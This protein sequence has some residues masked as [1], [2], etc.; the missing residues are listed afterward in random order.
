MTTYIRPR[1]EEFFLATL[2]LVGTL[3]WGYF[4][5]LG[6]TSNV[7]RFNPDDGFNLTGFILSF[8]LLCLAVF[9]LRFVLNV[10]RRLW[11]Q[12][13]SWLETLATLLLGATLILGGLFSVFTLVVTAYHIMNDKISNLAFT[14]GFS[15]CIV[16]LG[17]AGAQFLV[18]LHTFT[19]FIAGPEVKEPE[20]AS[21]VTPFSK[22]QRFLHGPNFGPQ[23]TGDQ[24][25]GPLLLENDGR[26]S[27]IEEKSNGRPGLEKTMV[28]HNGYHI[29]TLGFT[30]NGTVI[31]TASSGGAVHFQ[32]GGR[33]GVM[34]PPELKF[35]DWNIGKIQTATMGVPQTFLTSQYQV[36]GSLRDYRFLVP[37]GGQKFAWIQPKLLQVGSWNSVEVQQL[38]VEEGLT[39]RGWGSFVPLAFNPEGSRLAWCSTDGQTR[40]WNLET[41]QV[42]PL[43]AYP[44]TEPEWQTGTENGAWG[45]VFSPDGTRVATLGGQGILLQNV[46]TGWRWFRRLDD[47]KEKLSAFAF[48]NSGFEMAIGLMAR[49]A[50]AEPEPE[51]A[52]NNGYVATTPAPVESQPAALVPIVR[53]WDLREDRFTEVTAGDK[54]LCELA[55][56]SDGQWLAGV[57]ESGLLWLWQLPQEGQTNGT[58]R[59]AFQLDLGMNGHKIIVAFSPDVQHLVCATDNRILLWNMARLRQEAHV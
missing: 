22:L 27:Q 55:Y 58:P 30:A 44:I 42:Q 38:P 31:F 11:P 7:N 50:S 57:D 21:Q 24:I 54:P 28:A 33:K 23:R 4:G 48:S 36:P 37:S 3:I 1:L 14:E 46:Y 2:W 12:S 29:S 34:Y 18:G 17:L 49:P 45:L 15:S 56:S 41:D 43:R 40:L 25:N 9:G 47:D 6:Y 53:L 32:A 51:H 26:S 19:P 8:I 20:K 52:Q 10:F 13:P 39:L 5:I 59:L 16:I 35:W